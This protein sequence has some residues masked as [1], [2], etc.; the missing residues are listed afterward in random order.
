MESKSTYPIWLVT[1]LQSEGMFNFLSP[2]VYC[3]GPP[4]ISGSY[5][6]SKVY[7]D[8]TVSMRVIKYI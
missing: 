5:V 3:K 4:Y 8:A 7:N 1:Y 2:S 6:S